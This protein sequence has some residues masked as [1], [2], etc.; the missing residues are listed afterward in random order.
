M[1]RKDSEKAKE[2]RSPKQE[3]DE[4][5]SMDGFTPICE[6]TASVGKG[7]PGGLWCGLEQGD[8]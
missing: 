3:L 4:A 7:R 2:E 5:S 6:D 1:S 8:N